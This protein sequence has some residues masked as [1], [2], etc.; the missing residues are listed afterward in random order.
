M[1]IICSPGIAL[2]KPLE[3][4]SQSGV[5]LGNK[6][7]T[8]I[9]KGEVVEMGPD[10]INNYGAVIKAED[11]GKKG[12]VIYFLSYYQEGGY[13]RVKIEGIEYYLVKFGDFRLNI[14]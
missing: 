14:K 5:N 7:E 3:E 10:D 8:R 1:Q 13:D 2:V 9:L 11:Y 12:G 4:T 6:Q